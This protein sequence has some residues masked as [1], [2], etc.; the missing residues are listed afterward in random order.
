MILFRIILI[1]YAVT[2]KENL[3]D[4]LIVYHLDIHSDRHHE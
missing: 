4:F 2:L 3:D 1:L